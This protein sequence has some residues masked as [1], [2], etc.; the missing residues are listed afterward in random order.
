MARSRRN[1]R[2]FPE[3][4][5]RRSPRHPAIAVAIAALALLGACDFD[6]VGDG[7]DASRAP[8]AMKDPCAHVLGGGARHC[9][10]PPPPPDAAPDAP[11][12]CEPYVGTQDVCP[13]GC[14]EDQCT[15][16]CAG[17][18]GLECVYCE[19]GAWKTLAVD[20][21]DPPRDGGVDGAR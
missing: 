7:H 14:L 19:D 16:V 9:E 1:S 2:T 12:A 4:R 10:D 18:C 21:C 6:L 8:D 20:C 15:G 11:S 3:H 5:P 13:D 17:V